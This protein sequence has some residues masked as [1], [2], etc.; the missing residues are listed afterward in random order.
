MFS[1][2]DAYKYVSGIAVHWYEDF[3]TPVVALTSTHEKFPE[4]F[5]LATEACAGSLLPFGKVLLG[6]WERAESYAHDIIQ[7]L[8]LTIFYHYEF[9][10][11]N[12]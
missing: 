11:A 9:L 4:K 7:V 6:S 1:T 2:P 10:N 8:V 5:L 3:L 12:T